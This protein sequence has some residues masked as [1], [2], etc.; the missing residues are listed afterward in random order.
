M[1]F[2]DIN[3]LRKDPEMPWHDPQK[4]YV[5][6]W[7]SSSD[8]HDVNLFNQLLSP[9][10]LDQLEKEG[11]ACIVYTHFASGFV[12]D[13]GKLDPTFKNR[14][15]DLVSRDGWFVPCG[16]LLDYM[17]ERKRRR[18][19]TYLYKLFINIRWFFERTVK[20]VKHG[21]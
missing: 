11:G 6:Y 16:E 7:F 14:I 9:R 8:G 21:I 10:N 3:T 20:S 15:D 5:N 4:S 12:R 1:T 17:L 18:R 19:V 13:D 2:L